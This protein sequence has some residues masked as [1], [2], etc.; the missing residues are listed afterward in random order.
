MVAVLNENDR[1][2]FKLNED[3]LSAENMKL[4]CGLCL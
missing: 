4:A 3:G 1:V 2:C